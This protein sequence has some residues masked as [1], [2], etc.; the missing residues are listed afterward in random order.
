[1]YEEVSHLNLNSTQEG[2]ATDFSKI[3]ILTCSHLCEILPKPWIQ[4]TRKKRYY[5]IEWIQKICNIVYISDQKTIYKY[6]LSLIWSLF[7]YLEEWL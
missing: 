3:L 5:Y 2:L 4:E 1:M 6:I 7:P